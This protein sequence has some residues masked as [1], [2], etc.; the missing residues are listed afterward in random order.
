MRRCSGITR[1]DDDEWYTRREV[2]DK[3][4]DWLA[5]TG[6]LDVA[7]SRI[8]CPADLL[9]DGSESTIPKA[10]RARGFCHVRV[11][12]DLPVD[13]LFADW[14][15]GEVIVTNPP[16]S[17]LVSFRE[18]QKATEA[19][20]CMLGRPNALRGYPVRELKDK[21]HSTD[22]R[23]V[24]AAWMQNL[25]DTR[26]EPREGIEIGN[27]ALCER[28]RCPVNN[29]TGDW[30]PRKERKLYGWCHAVCHGLNGNWYG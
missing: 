13:V 2:A 11:T 20:Y 18:W 17:L 24:A 19:K 9:P 29:R 10:M 22:G 21:F 6:G 14:H 25:V 27:C 8:L 16:F 5:T 28:E 15:E 4:A 26:I 30:T 23:R 7:T 12:R 1:V 3:L